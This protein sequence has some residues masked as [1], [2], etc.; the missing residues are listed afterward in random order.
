MPDERASVIGDA[1]DVSHLVRQVEVLSPVVK[2]AGRVPGIVILE[3]HGVCPVCLRQDDTIFCCE[4]RGHS[5]DSFAASDAGLVISVTIDISCAV[6]VFRVYGDLREHSAVGPLK[7]HVSIGQDIAVGV[8]RQG[9]AI[10]AGEFILPGGVVVGERC[11]LSR[12]ILVIIDFRLGEDVSSL[13]VTVGFGELVCRVHRLG[14][15]TILVS[16]HCTATRAIS[17]SVDVFS[18]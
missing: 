6:R 18:S 1:N 14:Q 13:V 3:I 8:V 17:N 10:D 9:C 11:R 16:F 7:L 12:N 15:L 5:V 2:E 4:V